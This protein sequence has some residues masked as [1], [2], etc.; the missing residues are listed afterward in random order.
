MLAAVLVAVVGLTAVL[1]VEA[2]ANRSLTAKNLEPTAANVKAEMRFEL[3]RE[4][5]KTFHTGVSEDF[6]LKEDKFQNCA[7]SRSAKRP[8]FMANWRN[9]WRGR[10]TWHPCAALGNEYDELGI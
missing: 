7:R 9:C 5:I 3:G 10:P 1:A 2:K 8:T 6:L 4:A